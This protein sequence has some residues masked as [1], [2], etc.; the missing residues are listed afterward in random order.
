M[1]HTERAENEAYIERLQAQFD[2]AVDDLAERAL[3][4]QLAMPPPRLGADFVMAGHRSPQKHAMLGA[5]QPPPIPV[6]AMSPEP[7]P[8]LFRLGIG[9]YTVLASMAAGVVLADLL[10]VLWVLAR[11]GLLP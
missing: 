8:S 6:P 9:D 4:A 2:I 1:M 11:A 7:P 3:N 5:P 10:I